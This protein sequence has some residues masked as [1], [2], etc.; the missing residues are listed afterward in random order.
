M[1]LRTGSLLHTL[2]RQTRYRIS[3]KG[4]S[5]VQMVPCSKSCG[6]DDGCVQEGMSDS[7]ALDSEAPMHFVLYMAEVDKTQMDAGPWD[8]YVEAVSDLWDL[9]NGN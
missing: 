2:F 5:G 9:G 6:C 4:G 7:A 3:G 1:Q 8:L